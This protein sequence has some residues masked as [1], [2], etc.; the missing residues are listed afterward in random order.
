MSSSSD[1]MY[2][3]FKDYDF[4]DAEP[5]AAFPHLRR[6]Q[7]EH[8]GKTRITIHLDEAVVRA[9]KAKAG[10]RGYQTLINETLKRALEQDKLIEVIRA[11]IREELHH[12]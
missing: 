4:A 5:V 2:E 1:E 10:G 12:G 3:K 8:T 11:T 6:L 7:A 9:Y